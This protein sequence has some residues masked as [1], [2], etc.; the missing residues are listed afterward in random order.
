[1]RA[2]FDTSCA[3]D[4]KIK[5]GKRNKFD[6]FQAIL[7]NKFSPDNFRAKLILTPLYSR[8]YNQT[9]VQ[10]AQIRK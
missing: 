4:V 8:H 5:D 2:V 10:F 6:N 7:K 9:K 1:M 3:K